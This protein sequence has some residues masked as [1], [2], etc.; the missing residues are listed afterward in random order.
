[1]CTNL[2]GIC[3][4]SSQKLEYTSQNN[5]SHMGNLGMCDLKIECHKSTSVE[6]K[7]QEKR[8]GYQG[9]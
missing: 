6:H 2:F 5:F 8:N 1:M 7:A 3:S 4:R 9:I